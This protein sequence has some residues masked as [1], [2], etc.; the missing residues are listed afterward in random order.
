MNLYIT[1]MYRYA[2]KEK[3]SYV[4]GVF[5]KQEQ[6]VVEGELERVNRGNKYFPEVLEMKLNISKKKKV[7]LPV[8][9]KKLTNEHV[10]DEGTAKIL[11]RVSQIIL[12]DMKGEDKEQ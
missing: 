6:A 11:G 2:N 4:L 10:S 1:T 7:V 8:N 5:S 12:H 3:H 9:I